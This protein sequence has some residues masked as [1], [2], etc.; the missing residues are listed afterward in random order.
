MHSQ[1]LVTLM[2]QTL[3]LSSSKNSG[4]PPFFHNLCDLG[5]HL[6]SNAGNKLQR[7]SRVAPELIRFSSS[8]R[9]LLCFPLTHS[10][11]E[12]PLHFLRDL[13]SAHRVP[14]PL[15]VFLDGEHKDALSQ[16]AHFCADGYNPC[17]PPPQFSS[18]YGSDCV[19]YE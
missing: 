1:Q 5:R 9:A 16:M 10:R 3:T 14:P 11:P 4:L 2:M 6:R 12:L 7:L 8:C 15:I 19:L 18:C 13:R 17:G